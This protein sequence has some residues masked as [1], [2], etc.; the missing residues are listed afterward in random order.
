IINAAGAFSG[1]VLVPLSGHVLAKTESWQSVF[2]LNA[3]T[4]LLGSSVFLVFGTAKKII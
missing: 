4:L 1:I 2:H 3:I